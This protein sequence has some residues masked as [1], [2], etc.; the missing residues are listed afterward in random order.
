MIVSLLTPC[1]DELVPS[2]PL[3]GRRVYGEEQLGS[4]CAAALHLG[5]VLQQPSV[6][7]PHPVHPGHSAVRSGSREERRRGTAADD[8]HQ[9]LL[10]IVWGFLSERYMMCVYLFLL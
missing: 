8:C 3:S 1:W 6:Q 9:D 4:G 5:G 2:V 7:H 10:H